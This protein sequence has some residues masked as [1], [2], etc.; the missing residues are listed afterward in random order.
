MDCCFVTPMASVADALLQQ[1]L[2][3]ISGPI[4]QRGGDDPSLRCAFRGGEETLL[5]Q[6]TGLQPLPEQFLVHGDVVQQPVVADSIKAC[7]DIPFQ[8]PSRT[9]GTPQDLVTLIQGIG[10][11]SFPPKAIGMAI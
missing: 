3:L 9:G 5:L 4:R 10:A 8:N 7:F 6:E 1:L 2:E 11:A